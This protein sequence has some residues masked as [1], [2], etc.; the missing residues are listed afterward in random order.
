M[1]TSKTALENVAADLYKLVKQYKAQTYDFSMSLAAGEACKCYEALMSKIENELT[2]H[3]PGY[4]QSSDSN[5][6][7]FEWSNGYIEQR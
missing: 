3:L 1:N 6:P 2:P 4:E 7:L 5:A